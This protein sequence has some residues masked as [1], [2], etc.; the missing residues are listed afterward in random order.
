MEIPDNE[1]TQAID[2]AALRGGVGRKPK[3]ERFDLYAVTSDSMMGDTMPGL[4]RTNNEDS[5]ICCTKPDG[6]LSLAVVADGIGGGDYGEIASSAST[7]AMI[8]EWRKFAKKYVDTTWE[9]A[10]EFL[11]HAIAEANSQVY[12]ISLERDI[13]MGTTV[14][15]IQF[16]DRYAVIA[17]AGDSRVYRLRNHELEMLSTDHTQVAEAVQ[18][19]EISLNDAVKSPNRHT[20]TRALGVVEFMAPQIRVVDHKPGDCYLVCSD[21]LT[22]HVTDDEIRQEMDSCYDPTQCVDHLMR[23]TLQAGAHDNVTIISIFA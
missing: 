1:T 5:F 2:L 23:R 3:K 17:N 8:R 21:G 22:I 20:I 9:N 14:A 11:L 19:G 18:R 12:R 4:V 15:A 13:R 10:Q 7:A 6:H 16:A